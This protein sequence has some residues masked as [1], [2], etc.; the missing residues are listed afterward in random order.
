MA[1]K[2]D[3]LRRTRKPALLRR[4]F[5]LTPAVESI[6]LARLEQFQNEALQMVV[7][8]AYH[9]C[10][11]FREKMT[12]AGVKPADIRT[13][14]DVA[15][16]PF[17]TKEE[18]RT[19]PWLLLACDKEDILLVHTSTGTTGGQ[20]IYVPWTWRD[21]YL[22]ELS[23]G[24]P[25]LVDVRSGDICL[26]ALPY[27][28]SSAGLA[29]HKVFMDGCQATVIPAGKGGAYSSPDKTI[30][31]MRD[32]RPNVAIT[33]P[34]WAIQL[35][36]AAQEVGFDISQLSLKRMW[37]TGE[38]CSDAFRRRVETLWGTRA[39]FYYG[40][41]EC[42]GLGVE[43]DR[44]AGYHIP[45]AHVLV[46][47][48]DPET[49]QVL[50]PGE[51][52]EIAVTCLI[53]WDTP[54]IRYR[55]DDLGYIDPDPCE[56]GVCLPRLFLRGRRVEQL[57]VAGKSISPYYAE[58]FL[59]RMP[60]VGNWYHFVVSEDAQ[61]LQVQVELAPGVVAGPQLADRLASHLEFSLGVACEFRLHDRLPRPTSKTVRVLH[62]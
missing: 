62:E 48:I 40:S 10:A 34:S 3:Q 39:N 35:A 53:R 36:E 61:V 43:C 37:L 50:E 23:P 20:E 41:L 27:E 22:L 44:H 33:T 14:A 16:L 28:M 49:G 54:L 18:L 21:F 42:G 7:R 55:T 8:R 24:L 19:D 38:G 29:F 47:I 45:L 12:A 13:L 11:F 56:C 58:E 2:F 57:T 26:N 1:S 9:G 25:R 32:L 59:M 17:T 60:E 46:E 52:G 4:Y 30:R 15:R 5:D 51:I 31:V 6:P